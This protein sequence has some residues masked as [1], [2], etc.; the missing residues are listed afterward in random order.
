MKELGGSIPQQV[1]NPEGRG[2]KNLFYSKRD[3]ALI[4]DKTFAPGYGVLKAGTVCCENSSAA[5][6][7]GKVYPYVPVYGSQVA[8]LNTNAAIGV[9]PMV[10]NSSSGHVYVS[11]QD[12]YKFIVGDQIY[13]Q[14]T[15]G[16]GL[17][18]CGVITAIDRTTNPIYADI[19]T[20]A[21]TA[22]NGTIAKHAYVYVVSGSTP[23][24]IAK[25]ILDKDIDTGTGENAVGALGS[26]VLSNAILYS[27]SLINCT[28][29][30]LTSLGASTDG[31]FTILK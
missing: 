2:I 21:F 25:Y 28:A 20:G 14:N 6:N 31:R 18:D 13:F 29:A 9:A 16:D 11:I 30:A 15:S 10:A 3:I 1:M 19:S 17:V 12:S 24:S 26:V 4:T 8:A 5:G 22:T 23:F 7:K 27:A